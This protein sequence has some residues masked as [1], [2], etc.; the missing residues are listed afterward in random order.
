MNVEKAVE[1]TAVLLAPTAVVGGCLYGWKG[2][3]RLRQLRLERRART[4]PL[5]PR[6]PIEV[7]AARLRRMLRRREEL[8]HSTGSATRTHLVALESAI[9]DTASELAD[10]VGVERPVRVPSASLPPAELA[11]L[12]AR[13]ADAGIVLPPTSLHS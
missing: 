7:E 4:H 8:L 3:V 11:T 9:V 5:A 13:L 1:I 12:L 10:A 6:P 2:L